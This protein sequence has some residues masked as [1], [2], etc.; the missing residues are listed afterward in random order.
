M[1]MENVTTATEQPVII[2]IA[3]IEYNKIGK[4]TRGIF[5]P[6]MEVNV[7]EEIRMA[8]KELDANKDEKVLMENASMV[9]ASWF[10]EVTKIE[11]ADRT[12]YHIVG[13]IVECLKHSNGQIRKCQIEYSYEKV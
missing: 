8:I 12:E 10:T 13:R 11:L 3:T 6:T 5:K 9:L 7:P 2:G 1:K 4:M